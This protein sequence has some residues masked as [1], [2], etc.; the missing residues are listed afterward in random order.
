MTEPEISRKLAII[1]HEEVAVSTALVQRNEILAHQRADA[2]FQRFSTIIQAC[3][4]IVHEIC[5]DALTSEFAH[6][7]ESVFAAPTFQQIKNLD[8]EMEPG[9]NRTW[10]RVT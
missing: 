2:A 4:G 9:P 8:Q 7:F 6:L 1:V 10:L 3:G 5:G